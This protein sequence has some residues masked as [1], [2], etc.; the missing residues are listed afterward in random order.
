MDSLSVSIYWWMRYLIEATL[1]LK[2]KNIIYVSDIETPKIW[3]ELKKKNNANMTISKIESPKLDG[4]SV[5]ESESRIESKKV[6]WGEEIDLEKY[7]R[8]LIRISEK[9]LNNLYSLNSKKNIYI[10]ELEKL[11]KQLKNQEK[12]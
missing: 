3:I 12:I 7:K 9:Y 10:E 8:E 6:D 1:K 4:F 2:E 11:L 5:I